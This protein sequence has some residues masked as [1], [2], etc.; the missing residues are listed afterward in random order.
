MDMVIRYSAAHIVPS[1]SNKH[2]IIG[3]ESFWLSQFWMSAA[4]QAD[5]A[6]AGETFKSYL[7]SRDIK[8]RI[9]PPRCGSRNPLESKHG[10]IRSIFLKFCAAYPNTNLKLRAL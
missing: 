6:F 9:V 2:S 1:T 5:S 7:S 4:V 10:I 8:F 3:I